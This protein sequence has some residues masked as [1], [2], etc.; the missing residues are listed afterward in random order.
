LRSGFRLSAFV[1]VTVSLLTVIPGEQAVA[2]PHAEAAFVTDTNHARDHHD[3]RE[4][5]VRNHLT[6]V[7]QR[8]AEWMADHQTLRHNPYLQSQVHNWSALGEN[9]GSG[10]GEDSIQ[11]AFMASAPHRDNILSRSFR[12]VGIGTARGS[13]GKLYVDEVFRRPD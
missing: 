9:V 2:G 5:R 12:Q 1:L 7:A 3:R 10:P 4:Y 8:W 11:R 6:E 13:D